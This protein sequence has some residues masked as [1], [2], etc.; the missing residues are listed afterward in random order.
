MTV[1]YRGQVYV[2]TTAAEVVALVDKLCG[3]F[4]GGRRAA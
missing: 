1:T 2:V 4:G 3:P